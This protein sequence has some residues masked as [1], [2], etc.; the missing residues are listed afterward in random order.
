MRKPLRVAVYDEKKTPDRAAKHDHPQRHL[1]PPKLEKK[2]RPAELATRRF[3]Q[4][5]FISSLADGAEKR[6]SAGAHLRGAQMLKPS[7]YGALNSF[8][9]TAESVETWLEAIN[10]VRA[11]T[12]TRVSFPGEKW[13]FAHQP[14]ACC[15]PLAGGA[16]GRVQQLGGGSTA[17]T[18][19]RR[20]E[21]ARA[22]CR[23]EAA[24]RA[25][26]SITHNAPLFIRSPPRRIFRALCRRWLLWRS[27]IKRRRR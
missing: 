18:H 14:L 13:H 16:E 11:A 27:T 9:S 25:C 10:L 19:L 24:N 17:E 1:S 3:M 12:K 20:F 5:D 23:A 7:A 4:E 6:P 22:D 8:P 2:N 15:V 26:A 21:A